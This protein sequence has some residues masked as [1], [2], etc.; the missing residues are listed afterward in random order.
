MKGKRRHYS[1]E[2]KLEIVSQIEALNLTNTEMSRQCGVEKS[3]IGKWVRQYKREQ[4]GYTPTAKALTQ[5]QQTIQQLEKR[6]REIETENAIL[7]QAA[8]ILGKR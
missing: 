7:K 1:P 2:Y 3:L 8:I 5:E 6:L 4:Q